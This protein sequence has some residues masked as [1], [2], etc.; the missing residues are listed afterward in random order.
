MTSY[1][2]SL[3]SLAS[4]FYHQNWLYFREKIKTANT[5]Q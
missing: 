5:Y 1:Y 4:Y 3:L 2:L